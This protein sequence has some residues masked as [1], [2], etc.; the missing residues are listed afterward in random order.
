MNATPKQSPAYAAL[1]A[2]LGG[3]NAAAIAKYV[4][5]VV[6]SLR[7]ETD[8]LIGR[9][10][11]SVEAAKADSSAEAKASANNSTKAVKAADEAVAEAEKSGSPDDAAK[12][13]VKVEEAA[14]AVTKTEDD[15]AARVSAVEEIIAPWR[16]GEKLGSRP[17]SR[18]DPLEEDLVALRAEVDQVASASAHALAVARSG[19]GGLGAPLW[20]IGLVTFGVAFA[21][22]LVVAWLTPLTILD[23]V[24][25]ASITTIFVVTCTAILDAMG[26]RR[27][28]DAAYAAD[29]Q[30]DAGVQ[31]VRPQQA[32]H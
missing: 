5:E 12:A 2:Q 28:E 23:A 3:G 18:F 32:A 1:A 4:G 27:D 10:K 26:S 9:Q 19:G 8:E 25:W 11:A 31:I 13:K 20:L 30:A 17:A 22:L 29:A 21:I 15:L 14:Q 6:D 7:Q 16:N 24:I